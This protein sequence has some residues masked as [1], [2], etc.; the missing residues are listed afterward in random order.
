MYEL[1]ENKSECKI[2]ML[3]IASYDDK[4][5]NIVETWKKYANKFENVKIYLL[6][7]RDDLTE[8]IVVNDDDCTIFYNCEES[9]IPGIFLK[10]IYSMHYFKNRY[11]YDYLIR[12]N[13][14]SFY[15]IPKLVSF[16]DKQP[17]HNYVGGIFCEYY[18]IDFV[19]GAGIVM[20]RDIAEKIVDTCIISDSVSGS[21][22]GV[23]NENIQY[24]VNNYY[25]DIVIAYLI[26][27]HID[28]VNYK[29]NII[30]RY[31]V[32]EELTKEKIEELSMQF[33]H[34][35]NRNDST[36]RVMDSANIQ[37]LANYFY[38]V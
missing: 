11:N 9:F 32:E 18:V 6:Y 17:R 20:S 35:R 3:V 13:L 8:Q 31:S 19:S 23:L 1:V 34:F 15:N 26:N 22:T 37:L 24:Y 7:C 21:K 28:P 16:L 27:L 33:M 10:S 25:D 4:Y 12:T 38:G 36:N 14:S 5:A 29:N 2:L 30:H